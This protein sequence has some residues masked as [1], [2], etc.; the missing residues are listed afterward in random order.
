[1]TRA[2]DRLYVGGGSARKKKG[3]RMLVRPIADRPRPPASRVRA[4][5]ASARRQVKVLRFGG[6]SGAGWSGEG[7]EIGQRHGRIVR[8]DAEEMELEPTAAERALGAHSG[9]RRAQTHAAGA[10]RRARRRRA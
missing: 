3:T 9:A 6:S 8:P 7:Y 1:M 4:R 5:A 10:V 2:E